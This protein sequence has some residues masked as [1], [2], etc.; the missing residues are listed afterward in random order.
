MLA[1]VKSDPVYLWRKRQN[2][3]MSL[4][5]SDLES[6]QQIAQELFQ[7]SNITSH[8]KRPADK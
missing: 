4:I 1:L 7:N 8:T 5:F 3:N 2:E 6:D